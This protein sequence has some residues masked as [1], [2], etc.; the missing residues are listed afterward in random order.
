MLLLPCHLDLSDIAVSP[1]KVLKLRRFEF[2]QFHCRVFFGFK[3]CYEGQRIATYFLNSQ[4]EGVQS[5]LRAITL[6]RVAGPFDNSSLYNLRLPTV[7][8]LPNKRGSYS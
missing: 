8:I 3:L 7:G 5:V 6:G 2:F 1:V 4:I